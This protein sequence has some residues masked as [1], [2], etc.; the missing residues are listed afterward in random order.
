MF[1]ALLENVVDGIVMEL[2]IPTVVR[3]SMKK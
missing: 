2:K 1:L 3:S